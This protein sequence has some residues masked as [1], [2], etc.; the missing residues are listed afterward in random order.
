M[1]T[2]STI[3]GSKKKKNIKISEPAQY[4]STIDVSNLF[5]E[6]IILPMTS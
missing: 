3:Y 1:A 5:S 2:H 6:K 4:M